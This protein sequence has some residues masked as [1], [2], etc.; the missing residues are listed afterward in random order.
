M[1]M[2]H[3]GGLRVVKFNFVARKGHALAESIW[4]HHYLLCLHFSSYNTSQSGVINQDSISQNLSQNI[5]S[6]CVSYNFRSEK[7]KIT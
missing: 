7:Y 6:T 5:R 4:L 3:I 2:P 1:F